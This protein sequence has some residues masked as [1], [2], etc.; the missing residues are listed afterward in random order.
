MRR[1]HIKFKNKNNLSLLMMQWIL[2]TF[3]IGNVSETHSEDQDDE[4]QINEFRTDS[5]ENEFIDGTK[6]SQITHEDFEE[7]QEFEHSKNLTRAMTS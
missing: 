7:G 5:D 2:M 4:H 6:F 3:E 1:Q